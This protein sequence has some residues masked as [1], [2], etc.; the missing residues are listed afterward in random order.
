VF[1]QNGALNARDPLANE[2][3]S[4]YL[5]RFRAGLSAGGPIIRNRTFY[6]VAG[7]QEDAHADDSS[8]IPPSVAR[9]VN[10]V[11]GSG[12]FPNIATRT[13]DPNLFQTT[14]GETEISGRLD[15]HLYD[16]QSLLVKFALTNNRE[17]RDAFHSGGLVDP[18]GRGC[19]FIEDQ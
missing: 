1:L 4:P 6:Y 13:I 11:L 18:S 9:E 14:R 12:M 19:S 16:K 17:V 8:L 5:N 7:E 2:T 10:G 15:H 3:E